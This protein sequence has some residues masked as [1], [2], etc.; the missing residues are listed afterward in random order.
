MVEVGRMEDM[1]GWKKE[2]GSQV[3]LA[4]YN[5]EQG[6]VWKSYKVKNYFPFVVHC[7]DEYGINRCFTYWEFKRR[8][9][10]ALDALQGISKG[11]NIGLV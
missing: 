8:Q 9:R 7:V 3:R 11:R 6:W 10:G 5:T 4:M 1:E 2:V